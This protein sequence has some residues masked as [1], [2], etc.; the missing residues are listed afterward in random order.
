MSKIDSGQSS[1]GS[2]L[3]S[4]RE[5][6]DAVPLAVIVTSVD[7]VILLWNSAAEVLYGWAEDEVLGRQVREVLV[8]EDDEGR[9]E[10]IMEEIRAGKTWQGDFFVR[11]RDGEVVWIAVVD[12]PIVADDGSVR[13]V[14]GVSEDVADQRLLERSAAALADNLS[15]ALEAGGLG[16][17][18]WD[19]ASGQVLWDERLEA[20]Y[21][22]EPGTFDGTFEAYAGGLHPD[23]AAEV[24]ATVQAAVRDK[25]RYTVH[26]R[27][28]W[29]DGST[30]WLQGKGQVLADDAGRV[31]GTIGCVADVTEQMLVAQERERFVTIALESAERDRLSAQRLEFLGRINDVLTG[32]STPDEVMRTV[33]RAAVPTLGEWCAI[34]VLPETGS[35][36][37]DIEIAHADPAMVE[38]AR[39]LQER[40]PYEP[41][42]STGIPQVIRTGQSEFVPQIT[43]QMI[44]EAP[45]THEGRDIVR[46]LRLS[47]SIAV[48]LIKR[49]RVIGALQFVNT[50]ASRTYSE[51]DLALAEA[52]ASRIASTLENRRLAAHQRAI[53]TTLQAS[54][55]PG[56]LPTIEGLDVAVRYWAAGEGTEVGGD[57][58]DA[59]VVDDHWAVVIGDVCGTGPEAAALTGLARHT[60]RAAAWSGSSPQ[61][62]IDQL[63]QAVLRS[64][65]TTFCTALFCEIYRVADGF[66]VTVTAGGH[67]LPIIRR[68]ENGTETVGVP[69]SLIGAFDGARSTT[70]ETGLRAGD[71]MVL[72]TD[73]VTDLPP[74]HGMDLSEMLGAVARAG[75]AGTS[76]DQVAAN[77]GDEIASKL[78]LTDR[79]DDIALLVLKVI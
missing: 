78:P 5:V 14:V 55:L 2:H 74:P 66:R 3:I 76:A 59:F 77:L 36:T 62:V 72:Y 37:P 28:V 53:A 42:A 68:G 64:D 43:E 24:L 52:V 19:M 58:Y 29:P 35:A 21:G 18:R 67:P 31:T 70:C 22:L 65:R 34:F 79:N 56:S 39:G 9:A 27:V 20:L 61:V 7:G 60:I 30:H 10:D 73:G 26:H 51:Q 63:N 38:F 1:S 75:R 15:L 48:P 50:D 44:S 33:T 23:D 25:S 11:R 13:A 32:A 16:T 4:A 57:F 49:G 41:G 12:R 17:W 54:L 71:S 47:S 40:F 45:G 8:G 69:G 6:V 46:N